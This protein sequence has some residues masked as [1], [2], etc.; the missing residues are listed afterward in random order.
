MPSVISAFLI[1]IS[2]FVLLSVGDAVVKSMSGEWPGTAVSALRYSF[3]ALGLGL[4]VA[5]RHG[6]AGFVLPRPGLQLGRGAAVALA[7]ICFFMGVMA[8]PLADATAIQFTSPIMTALLAPLVLGERTRP[9]TWG[10]T[11]LAFA[12]V[13]IVLRPNVTELGIVAFWPLGAAFGM[14]WLM[15]LNR[16][17]AGLAPVMVMQF[18]LAAIA[19]PLLVAAAALLD[20]Y[21]GRT[22]DVGAPSVEVVLKCLLVAFT[23]TIGHA[24]IFAAAERASASLVAPMTYAQLLV[25]AVLG[26]AW[27][28]DPL[29]AATFGGAALIIAGGLWLWRAQQAGGL[30][31]RTPYV[32]AGEGTP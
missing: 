1:A 15:M 3:G 26:W 18:I 4:Y 22:F 5:L 17:T 24:L 10:A 31:R 12:G 19:A 23:A 8:M 7:T 11:L 29:D 2:G 14:S 32:A 6:R 16:K 25:A 27:F 13:L 28:G 9:A 21:A 30:R 20:A